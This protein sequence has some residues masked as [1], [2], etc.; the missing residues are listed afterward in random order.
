MRRL[1]SR[2]RCFSHGGTN[3]LGLRKLQVE[4]STQ[5]IDINRLALEK[6]EDTAEGGLRIGAMVH[7][8]DFAADHRVRK[9][10]AVLSRASL[11]GASVQLRNKA[12]TGGNLLQRRAAIISIMSLGQLPL[13]L[14]EEPRDGDLEQYGAAPE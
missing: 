11:A 4:T 7:N 3:L 6:I 9:H 10:Y 5:L 12:T 1:C 2:R 14:R 8:S 13:G